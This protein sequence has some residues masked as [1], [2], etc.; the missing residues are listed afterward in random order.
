MGN[1]KPKS[2]NEWAE[3]MKYILSINPLNPGSSFN[4]DPDTFRKYVKMQSNHCAD[5][6]FPYL[7]GCMMIHI[8]DPFFFRKKFEKHIY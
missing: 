2:S 6:N 3:E 5:D 4:N 1:R 7:A 8:E